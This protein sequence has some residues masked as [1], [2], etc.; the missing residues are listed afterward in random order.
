MEALQVKGEEPA[1]ED[2][3]KSIAT[4]RRVPFTACDEPE[5]REGDDTAEERDNCR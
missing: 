1:G 5:E 3:E 4:A 2:G